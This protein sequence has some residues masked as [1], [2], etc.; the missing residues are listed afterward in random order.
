M[1]SDSESDKDRKVN[2]MNTHAETYD[3]VDSPSSLNSNSLVYDTMSST[4][5]KGAVMM[6]KIP[7]Y[8]SGLSFYNLTNDRVWNL[9]LSWHLKDIRA[10]K[11]NLLIYVFIVSDR[12]K[13]LT[14]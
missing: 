2:N 5:V 13:H 6:S 7:R 9:D 10:N 4:Q 14:R 1:V 8:M 3:T 11:R 12:Y